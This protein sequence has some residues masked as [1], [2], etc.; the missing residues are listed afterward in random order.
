[1]Y[2]DAGRSAPRPSGR[3]ATVA[4]PPSERTP[5]DTVKL[6]DILR[7]VRASLRGGW[8]PV[9]TV[10]IAV[11]V[12]VGLMALGVLHVYLKSKGIVLTAAVERSIVVL[13]GPTR[14]V[15]A[16]GI[17]VRPGGVERMRGVFADFGYDIA[18]LRGDRPM[19][20]R[21]FVSPLPRDLKSVRPA[22]ER[23]KLFVQAVLPQ[24]L[25]VNEL[26]LASRQ[27]LLAL[28]DG[29]VAGSLGRRDRQWL[30][31]L[32]GRYRVDGDDFDELMRRVDAVPVPLALA[33]A[34]IESGW[35]TSRFAREGN[36]LFGQWTWA[37]R[38][39]LVPKQRDEGASHSIRAF[40]QV[41]DSVSAYVRNLN[42][43]PAYARFR[44][45][46][47]AI[48]GAGGQLDSITLSTTLD[49]YSQR[50]AAYVADIRDIIRRNRL[51]RFG[52]ARLTERTCRIADS[53]AG[54]RRAMLVRVPLC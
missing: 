32:K 12:V 38:G 14:T 40:R 30:A 2:H 18:R 24:V 50:G 27:R 13:V 43:H 21:V 7:A 17:A 25:L 4:P 10:A 36:A 20:P 45:V 54:G 26:V 3:E 16:R 1:M 48:R 51:G 11:M 46:R 29:V 33:Q 8:S 19:V 53:R 23:K 39:G 15:R 31:D 47:A 42:T 49:R 37:R 41:A 5:R 22:S 44:K 6:Q 52:T 28:R 34:A 9:G 35:G